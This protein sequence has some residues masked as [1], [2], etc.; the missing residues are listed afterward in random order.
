[1]PVPA[2]GFL[3]GFAGLAVALWLLAAIFPRSTAILLGFVASLLSASALTWRVVALNRTG[4]SLP[5]GAVSPAIDGWAATLPT[6][7]WV[8]AAVQVLTLAAGYAP[9]GEQFTAL[10]VL[11]L[12]VWPHSAPFAG[13]THGARVY[14]ADGRAVLLLGLALAGSTLA[15]RGGLALL[16]RVRGDDISWYAGRAAWALLT[17]GA[18][19]ASLAS[20]LLAWHIASA[21]G[22]WRPAVSWLAAL[23]AIHL[24]AVFSAMAR[25]GSSAIPAWVVLVGC[26]LLLAYIA[27]ASAGRIAGA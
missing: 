2:A 5:E 11:A 1:M 22:G 18:L 20:V 9:W 10:L 27:L 6:F 15:A 12:I 17:V 25:R 19:A 13:L 16:A 8:V 14:G 21:R 26:G 23:A 24:L 4:L 3:A 7:A